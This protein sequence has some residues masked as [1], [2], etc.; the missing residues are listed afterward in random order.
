[1]SKTGETQMSKKKRSRKMMDPDRALNHQE[2]KVPEPLFLNARKEEPGFFFG[3]LDYRQDHYVGLPQGIDGHI[4]VVGGSGSGKSSGIAMPTLRT[5]QGAICATDVKG[6]LSNIYTKLFHQ[7]TAN[8]PY[9]IFDPTQVDGPSYDPYGWLQQDDSNNL[10]SNI[11]DLATAIIPS[12]ATS[13]ADPFWVESEQS[14]L[15]AAL[16]HY[17]N[18]GLSFSETIT[19]I[20]A[21][22]SLCE[23]LI[24]S[25]D[26]RVKYFV[27]NAMLKDSRTF[28]GIDRGLRN[29]IILFANDEQISHAFR[30]TREGAKCFTWDDLDECN[31]FLRIPADK[32]DEWSSAVTLMYA[33]L[34]R[35]FERRPEKFTKNGA[36]NIQTL[37]L[38][39][40]FPRFGK[41]ELITNAMTTLRSKSV[42]L[43][44]I[45]QS[46]AQLDDIYGEA[47]RRIVFNECDFVVILRANDP[48][49]QRYLAERI[50]TC[51]G[52]QRSIAENFDTA[53]CTT[54]C[55]KHVSETREWRISPHELSTLKDILLLSP[56]GFCRIDK[57]QA[58]A[59]DWITPT[60]FFPLHFIGD[61]PYHYTLVDGFDNCETPKRNFIRNEGARI[62][63]FEERSQNASARAAADEHQQRVDQRAAREARKKT[64]QRRNFIIGALVSKYF[65]EVMSFEPGTNA[66]NAER[67]QPL[68]GFLAELASD[69]EL[70]GKIKERVHH[71]RMET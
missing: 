2:L 28:A 53:M 4:M 31:I 13:N 26:A 67:F 57:F 48:D 19:S 50:G 37:L 18:L 52:I 63:T 32:V 40:E 68:K 27:G 30:G 41:L 44:L 64:D 71:A 10:I 58:Y 14:L 69:Q 17:F 39:D 11:W 16:L 61:K 43:C 60:V 66:E 47:K 20:V 46:I 62:L 70:V 24:K 34:I 59:D 8:R 36:N 23:D 45:L 56:Y 25:E 6:E 21:A 51:V 15:A 5:W 9:I 7:G 49:T 35:Y 1:L 12:Q 3:G 55:S 42:T 22:E 33:Q 29:K 38:M 65:P 54:G